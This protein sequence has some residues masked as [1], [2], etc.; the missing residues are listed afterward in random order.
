MLEVLALLPSIL[1]TPVS[2]EE[3]ELDKNWHSAVVP[4]ERKS[5]TTT[6]YDT[7]RI[8]K[9][10]PAPTVQL[11]EDELAAIKLRLDT[12]FKSLDK[13]SDPHADMKDPNWISKEE[14]AVV[15]QSN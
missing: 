2:A 3:L 7:K 1:V 10:Y 8:H 4:I 14:P 15:K 5:K 13:E 6:K 12:K 9:T 11:S